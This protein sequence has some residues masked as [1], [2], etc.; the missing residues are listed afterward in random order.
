MK[1]A[2]NLFPALVVLLVASPIYL[3]RLNDAAG[4]VVDDAWY[5]MLARALA[6]GQGY[7]LVNAPIEGI[8]PGYPPGF[9]AMLSIV[10]RLRS[11]F[12]ENVRLLKSVS[13]LA[14]FG[15]G[16]L[17]YLHARRRHVT[18]ELAAC[19]ATAVTVTPAFVFLATSTVMTECVF[20]LLQ[21]ATILLIHRTTDLE[22]SRGSDVLTATAG[23]MAAATV[24]VR[25]AGIALP[26]AVGLWLIKERRWKRA[27]VFG[28]TATACLLPWLVYARVNAPTLEAQS[29]HGGSIVYSYGEQVRMRWAGYPGAGMATAVDL[30]ARVA[31]NVGDVTLRSM[32][33]LLAPLVLRAPEESG[34]EIAALGG[35]VGLMRG[36]MGSAGATMG[37][38]ALLSVLVL[39]GFVRAARHR[40]TAAEFLVATTLAII[41]IWPFWTFRFLVPLL[42]YLMVYLVDG[43]ATLASLAVAR[44][45]ILCLI[46]LNISDH[47]RYVI[48]ARDLAASTPVSWLVQARETDEALKWMSAHLGPEVVA[49]TNP[50]LVY[51]RTGRKTIAFDKPLD[52][53]SVWRTRGVR[54]IASFVPAQLP[55]PGRGVF[56][57]LYRSPGGFWVIEI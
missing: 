27:A 14:M 46:G 7:T 23:L 8:L 13:I 41:A 9:P 37:M 39:A 33:G 47:V 54:Y 57:I 2:R 6:T 21:L 53:W 28:A 49:T 20:T 1:R 11:S 51:L 56:R 43:V 52:D 31:T 25:S 34:E 42:P 18:R 38:S 29:L 3:L 55:A 19:V 30:P 44:I 32:V 12:P 36:S 45:M 40:V 48:N 5:V 35:A 26:L 24:L 17:S 4:L 50:G 10:F 15:V 16:F 22:N